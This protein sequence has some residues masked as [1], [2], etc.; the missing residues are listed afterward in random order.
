MM[1]IDM[2]NYNYIVSKNKV[3]LT[4]YG[5]MHLSKSTMGVTHIILLGCI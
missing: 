3:Y 4:I 2:S 5:H 1:N